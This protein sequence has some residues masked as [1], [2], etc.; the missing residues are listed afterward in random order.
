MAQ[1]QKVIAS[2]FK[3]S[4]ITDRRPVWP[5]EYKDLLPLRT[6]NSK[7]ANLKVGPFFFISSSFPPLSKDKKVPQGSVCHLGY[8]PFQNAMAVKALE[9]ARGGNGFGW[10]FWR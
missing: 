1:D 10:N 7:V 5:A 8:Y 9:P 2:P 6:K 4:R 3:G